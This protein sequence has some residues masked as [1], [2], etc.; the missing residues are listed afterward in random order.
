MTPPEAGHLR[1]GLL[2]THTH[3]RK[4]HL[5]IHTLKLKIKYKE[6]KMKVLKKGMGR[7]RSAIFDL[8]DS[9]SDSSDNR[10]VF[11]LSRQKLKI[12]FVGTGDV[13]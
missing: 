2:K 7:T 11:L 4:G 1:G 9:S 5:R 12:N 8:N 6:M 3:F 10:K 13:P